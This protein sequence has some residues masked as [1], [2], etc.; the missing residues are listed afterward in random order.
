MQFPS[1]LWA[2]TGAWTAE[3]ASRGPGQDPRGD[4]KGAESAGWQE[5]VPAA[6]QSE[7]RIHLL[8]CRHG[9]RSK[10]QVYSFCA[11]IFQFKGYFSHLLVYICISLLY[12]YLRPTVILNS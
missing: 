7:P 5:P 3:T 10:I 1:Q 8:S 9:M 4:G 6:S 12:T 11:T 2:D